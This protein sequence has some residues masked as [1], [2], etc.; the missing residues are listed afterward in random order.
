MEIWKV[1]EI[2]RDIINL[3]KALSRLGRTVSCMPM[4][5]SSKSKAKQNSAYWDIIIDEEEKDEQALT[6]N[7]SIKR[8]PKYWI[9][10]LDGRGDIAKTIDL[11][12]NW[13]KLKFEREFTRIVSK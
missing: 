11:F 8:R 6:I 10:E 5:Y 12:S 3:C 9:E 7:Y 13:N 2:Q 4:T 1:S